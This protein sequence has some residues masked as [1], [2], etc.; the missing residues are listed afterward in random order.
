[1][2]WRRGKGGWWEG[3]GHRRGEK[4]VQVR[5]LEKS[6]AEKRKQSKSLSNQITMNNW[7]RERQSEQSYI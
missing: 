1:V 6:S 3:V 4:G 2:E 7:K 5:G